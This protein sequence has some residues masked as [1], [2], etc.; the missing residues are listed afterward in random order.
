MKIETDYD[1][2]VAKLNQ[3]VEFGSQKVAVLLDDIPENLVNVK[4]L[5]F[6]EGSVH[7]NLINNL[8][9]ELCM[10]VYFVPRVY[11]YEI[12]HRNCSYI[13]DILLNLEKRIQFSS[14]AIIL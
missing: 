12:E 2:L 14:V 13:H 1:I 9:N 3:L 10:P 5:N 4:K 11:A 8:S 7:A 6:S